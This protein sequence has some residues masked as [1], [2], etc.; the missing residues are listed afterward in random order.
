MTP[1]RVIALVVVTA[2]AGTTVMLAART[3]TPSAP[4]PRWDV[5]AERARRD[6]DIAWYT[7]RAARDPSGAMD[8]LRLAGLYLQ[9]ARERGTPADLAR[10]EAEARLSLAHRREHNAEAFRALALALVGQHRFVEAAAFADSLLADD[11]TSASA[12]SLR[13]EIAL[14]LGRYPL[15]DSIF[16]GLDR[17]GSDPA[18]LARVAR[19]ASL[20]G[21][22]AHAR[23]LLER[24][25]DAA[26]TR[27]GT[28]AEQ[29]AWYD[30]R[31][32]EL[33]LTVGKMTA[34]SRALH[35]AAAVV[36]DDPR[37]LLAQARVALAT[38]RPREALALA[39]DAMN[40]GEDPL[41]FALASDAAR[42]LGQTEASERFF[43]A[44]EVAIAAAPP[45]AWHR[46]WRFA[47]LDRG[48]QI[49]TV[50]AQAREEL[51][52][53]RDVQGWDLYA[54]A[55]HRAGR[56]ADARVAMR[57]ALR[58]GTEDRQ[59]DEHAAALGV[60]R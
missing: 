11:P 22:A 40:H 41:A 23:T 32:G 24:A 19:W 38:D 8:R 12:R 42:R 17:S 31:L 34:A 55:L 33:A 54:W 48:R 16:S 2:V 13:G 59:L 46:A 1:G 52:T 18:V 45:S 6:A 27:A 44:F 20:R 5:A 49:D 26:R 50:L 3:R 43:R 51:A 53:R 21:R 4:S 7:A 14:E 57:E 47:L 15:A 36:P 58:W 35:D 9:R 25:R 60:S 30:L 56:D 29:I 10:A 37:I 28:P 39:E